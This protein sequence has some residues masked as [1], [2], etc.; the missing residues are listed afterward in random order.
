MKAI[1]EAITSAYFR[2]PSYCVDKL[3]LLLYTQNYLDRIAAF[4]GDFL[5]DD[6]LEHAM[7]ELE[8]F[9]F[10]IQELQ[11]SKLKVTSL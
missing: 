8:L 2:A 9:P 6:Y 3:Q 1:W 5:S 4:S 11:C 7:T 10:A